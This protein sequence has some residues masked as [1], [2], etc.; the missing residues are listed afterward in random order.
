[1]IVTKKQLKNM[2]RNALFE[3]D[4]VPQAGSPKKDSVSSKKKRGPS[5]VTIEPE[6]KK[7]ASAIQKGKIEQ[8]STQ[9][10]RRYNTVEISPRE[11]IETGKMAEPS[12]SK[13]NTVEIDKA[14]LQQSGLT[15]KSSEQLSA[16]GRIVADHIA[17][18][19]ILKKEWNTLK[20]SI[21]RRK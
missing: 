16:L 7:K 8:P 2:I 17:D 20:Q 5:T 12:R 13:Q 21:A 6:D 15:T 9:K 11:K 1:M 18:I 19:A 4:V 3:L 10:R 14:A